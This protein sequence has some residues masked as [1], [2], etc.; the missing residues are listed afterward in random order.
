MKLFSYVIVNDSGFAPNPYWGYCTLATCK[1]VIRSTAK[2]GDWVIGIGSKVGVGNGKLV[3]AMHVSDVIP[4]EQY[5]SD[6]RFKLKKPL[7]GQTPGRLCGDNIYYKGAGGE[8][9]QR[10]SFHSA[11]HMERD[12]HGRNAL[13]AEHFYYF[14]RNAVEVPRE[15]GTLVAKG[16]GHRCAFDLEVTGAFISWL[17]KNFAPG[18]HGEPLNKRQ[19]FASSTRCT[20]PPTPADKSRAC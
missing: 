15:F 3:Y 11:E 13:V 8:W 1:P 5:N 10:R 16:R 20:K 17:Q 12:L 6:S 19:D 4:F 9:M 14:G 18:T 2:P 7:A